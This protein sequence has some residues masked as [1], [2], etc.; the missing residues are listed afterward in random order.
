MWLGLGPGTAQAQ[1]PVRRELQ[2]HTYLP[3]I[4]PAL[5]TT[6]PRTARSVHP[7]TMKHVAIDSWGKVSPLKA[8]SFFPTIVSS[9]FRMVPGK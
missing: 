5:P 4:H 7:G 9:M 1:S 2:Q 6:L 8:I 3:S